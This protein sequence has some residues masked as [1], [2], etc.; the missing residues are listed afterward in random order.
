MNKMPI[1]GIT[2]GDP[3]GIGPEIVVKTLSLKDLWTDAL[4]VIFGHRSAFLDILSKINCELNLTAWEP[5]VTP[6]NPESG[7]ISFVSVADEYPAQ[8]FGKASAVGGK[9]AWEAINAAASLGISGVID[10]LVTAPISKESLSMAGCREIGHTEILAKM[11]GVTNYAMMLTAKGIFVV[12]AT[13]HL[14]LVQACAALTETLIYDKIKLAFEFVRE[15]RIDHLPIAVCGLNPHA[16][17][18]GVLGAEESTIIAPAIHRA[19]QEGISVV[20][21]L[22]A[23]SIFNRA[24][25]GDFKVII[26]LYHD[27]GHIPVKLLGIMEGVNVTLGLPFIR[28]SVDHGTAFGKAGNGT[29]DPGS[30]VAAVRLA[31]TLSWQ[32]LQKKQKNLAV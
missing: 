19:S 7:R 30:M 10:A 1:L 26:A 11:A 3:A 23:D 2:L 20:G 15:H 12:H 18:N 31:K 16:G 27:Q 5:G 28:T 22:P 25:N 9:M 17:E 13:V 8:G 32:R 14:P 29:A 24:L 4:P 6:E 21:P